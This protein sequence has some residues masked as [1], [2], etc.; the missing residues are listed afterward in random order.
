MTGSKDDRPVENDTAK[1]LMGHGLQRLRN[2]ELTGFLRPGMEKDFFNWSGFGDSA[3]AD[4]GDLI[5]N[6]LNYA[7]FVCDDHRRNAKT[8]ID[9]L[10]EGKDGLGGGRVQSRRCLI[11]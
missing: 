4:Y 8:T 5:T 10:D 2:D 6:L 3:M 1:P 7:H 9:I 11:A